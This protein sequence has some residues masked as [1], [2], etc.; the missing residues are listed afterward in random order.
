[1]KKIICKKEYDT[2]TAELL[3]KHTEGVFGEPEGYEESLY[4]TSAGTYFLYVNG[5]ENSPY[6]KNR[7]MR[8]AST[9]S[10]QTRR[11]SSGCPR[12][13]PKSGLPSTETAER[14]QQGQ[15][16]SGMLLRFF[17]IP[18]IFMGCLGMAG[19]P[20]QNILTKR[21]KDDILHSQNT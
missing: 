20:I 7:S 9:A 12:I 15:G 6:P 4:Q 5:G 19:L 13:R 14:K 16:S 18:A 3:K 8:R 10:G 2:E 1:M 21:G 11:T 17:S